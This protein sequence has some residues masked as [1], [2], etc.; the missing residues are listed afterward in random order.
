[1]CLMYELLEIF[2]YNRFVLKRV[3]Y[4]YFQIV[5]NYKSMT[6]Y[7]NDVTNI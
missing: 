7:N 3:V 2:W 5:Y 6:F 4:S 1:M